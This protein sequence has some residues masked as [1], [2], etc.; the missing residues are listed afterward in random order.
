MR[1]TVQSV[2]DNERNPIVKAPLVFA[3][4]TFVTRGLPATIT[5][6]VTRSRGVKRYPCTTNGWNSTGLT[7][8]RATV[9]LELTGTKR[10]A[11]A[12]R[13]AII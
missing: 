1:Y 2:I 11:R 4:T 10:T 12:P 3:F 6:T 7:A 13:T 9:A 5:R 8:G